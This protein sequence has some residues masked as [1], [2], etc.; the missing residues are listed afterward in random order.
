MW[1]I[2]LPLFES[3]DVKL[4]IPASIQALRE[5]KPRPQFP[6]KGR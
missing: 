4:A 2:A 5:G 6:F 1:E 3:E